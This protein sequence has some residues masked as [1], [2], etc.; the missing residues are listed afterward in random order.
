MA[1]PRVLVLRAAGVNCNE[2]TAYAFELAGASTTQ[3]HVN[4]LVQNPKLLDDFG[5]VA[6]PGGFSYG[7]DIASGRVLG[8]ELDQVLGEAMRKLLGRGGLVLGICNGFQVLT[9]SG[10]LPGPEKTGS[11]IRASLVE[12]ESHRYEDRWV[13]MAVNG[14]KSLFFGAETQIELPVAHG[15]GRFVVESDDDLARLEADD[16]IVLRYVTASGGPASYPANPNGAMAGI[17][18]I[19]D[20]SG[21]VFGLMPHPERFLFPWQHPTWTRD[22]RREVGDGLAIFKHAVGNMRS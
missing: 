8:L 14:K 15:E 2:E 19:C 5:A 20:A 4:R 10:L 18:G 7:D 3:I 9:K 11:G 6:I 1:E 21:Q 22:R 12:N 16:R 17:A 13:H